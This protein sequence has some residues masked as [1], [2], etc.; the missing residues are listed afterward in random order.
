M[1]QRPARVRIIAASADAAFADRLAAELHARGFE[2]VSG[3]ESRGLNDAVV[4][5][6]SGAAIS[7]KALIDAARGPLRDNILVP[8]SIGR[9]EP[10]A[11]FRNLSA[12]DFASWSGDRG[13]PR[14]AALAD[15]I[16]QAGGPE[17][18][19]VANAPMADLSSAP[20]APLAS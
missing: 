15:A 12:I 14:F 17:L 10:Q 3:E 6:W 13:D 16:M 1:S 19:S 4:V 18:P 7:S 2:I 5:V 8:V 9:V 11:P 20:A